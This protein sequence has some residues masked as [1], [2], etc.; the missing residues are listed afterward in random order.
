MCHISGIYDFF[1][2]KQFDIEKI[3]NLIA[4]KNIFNLEI[5]VK[6]IKKD[7]ELC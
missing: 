4:Q 5:K 2:K 3:I 6:A 1:F 7:K